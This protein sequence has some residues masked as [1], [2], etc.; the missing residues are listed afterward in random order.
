MSTTNGYRFNAPPGWQVPAGW[1]PPEGWRPDPNWPPAPSGWQFWVLDQPPISAMPDPGIAEAAPRQA[2]V[3]PHAADTAPRIAE[4]APRQAE[5]APHV[6]NAAPRLAEV[7]PPVVPVEAPVKQEPSADISQAELIH[8][9]SRIAELEQLFE[10]MTADRPVD[11]DDERVLQEVGIYRYHHPL[12]DA[13]QFKNQLAIIQEH[14]KLLVKNGK[15]VLVSDKFTFNNSLAKGRKMSSD[16]AKLMLR[17]YNAEADNCVRSL[18]AG[19]V[20][21]AKQRLDRCANAV[22]K[23]GAMMEIQLNPEY[24]DLR[25]KEIELVSDFAVKKQEEREAEREERARL[26]EERKAA[27]EFAAESDR[28]EKERRHL[29]NAK[30]SLEDSGDTEA[31]A[32]LKLKLEELEAAIEQNESRSANIRAGYVYV[33]SNAGAFGPNMVKIGMTRRL[34]PMDR[35]RELGDA[36]VPFPFDVHALFFSE[37]AVGLETEL[38]EAFT[39][40]RVNHVNLRREFFFATPSDVRDVLA[41]KVGNL[42]EFN[43][44]PKAVQYAQSK[45]YWPD[46]SS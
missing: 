34:D 16:L 20:E 39:K 21:T 4:V 2:E 11:L 33:I 26:R 42:L 8:L 32:E 27:Q 5:V 6:G 37:D 7:A 23:L 44:H 41:A 13:A 10:E 1:I 15:A 17:A 12:E 14:I 9:R 30:E 40:Q 22:S 46:H 38:H 45:H 25:L 28:L 36:S 3:T 29:I 31:A 19:N 43:E 24:H 18:K 35:V